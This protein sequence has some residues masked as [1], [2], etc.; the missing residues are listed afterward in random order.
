MVEYLEKAK[1]AKKLQREYV[2]WALEKIKQWFPDAYSDISYGDYVIRDG[3]TRYETIGG[4]YIGYTLIQFSLNKISNDYN[5]YA[6]SGNYF[7]ITDI[8]EEIG[9][10]LTE[11][12][13]KEFK[14]IDESYPKTIDDFKEYMV[15]KYPDKLEMD[16]QTKLCLK[17]EV[18]SGRYAVIGWLDEINFKDWHRGLLT[19]KVDWCPFNSSEDKD[20]S[21]RPDRY[22]EFEKLF[23]KVFEYQEGYE[24]SLTNSFQENFK[25]D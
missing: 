10:D 20:V 8:F 2:D 16:Y 7:T 6:Y 25:L 17:Y 12:K 1:E 5:Q 13:F 19:N 18:N 21:L 4:D 11:L 9:K 14:S 24:K 3:N 23:V 22:R 15:K